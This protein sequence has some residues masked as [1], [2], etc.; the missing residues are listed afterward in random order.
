MGRTKKI[1]TFDE[2]N[3]EAER[4]DQAQRVAKSVRELMN[5]PTYEYLQDTIDEKELEILELKHQI[6]GYKAVISYLEH[7]LGLGKSQ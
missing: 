1:Y 3:S 5:R 4:I 7:Q 6:V 2:L